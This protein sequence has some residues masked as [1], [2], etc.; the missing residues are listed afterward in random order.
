M[1]RNKIKNIAIFTN[2]ENFLNLRWLDVSSNKYTELVPF[3]LPKLDYLDISYNRIE[4]INEN[5][6]GHPNVK[7]L[8]TIDNKFKSLA[9][10]K[11]MP[12]LTE[13]FLAQNMV[14]S[15]SG[16]EAMPTLKKLNLR[17]NKIEK[18][19]EELP[20]LESLTYLNL[21]GNRLT[22]LAQL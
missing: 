7:I 12:M 17:K 19:E 3:K 5:W 11:D 4:K 10:F 21:R 1:A 18:L 20:S 15:I 14:S 2:E 8:K 6:T 16:F 9:P 22:S 13:L